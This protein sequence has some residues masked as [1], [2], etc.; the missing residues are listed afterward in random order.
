M[1]EKILNSIIM[2]GRTAKQTDDTLREL[3]YG[4]T[5]Y[6]QIY[7]H[8]T[9]ALYALFNEHTETFDQSFTCRLMNCEHFSPDTCIE[10]LA[11]VSEP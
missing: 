2:A 9:D 3:G 8:I 7:G 4:A 10:L 5:P 11:L 6:F 1:N